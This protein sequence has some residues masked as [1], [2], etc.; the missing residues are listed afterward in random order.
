VG[1]KVLQSFASFRTHCARNQN[2]VF[3][4]QVYGVED[5]KNIWVAQ[6]HFIMDIGFPG[7]TISKY[8]IR[9]NDD[10]EFSK[11]QKHLQRDNLCIVH[12]RQVGSGRGS[13]QK[14]IKSG[15]GGGLACE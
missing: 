9:R 7:V 6:F 10:S 3:E 12:S 5:F 1:V 4:K 11:E 14:G 2:S 15:G 8:Y 13:V